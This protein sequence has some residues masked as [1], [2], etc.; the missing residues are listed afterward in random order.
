MTWWFKKLTDLQDNNYVLRCM[1]IMTLHLLKQR[2]VHVF[3][4]SN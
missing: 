1:I 3:L 2:E 4:T